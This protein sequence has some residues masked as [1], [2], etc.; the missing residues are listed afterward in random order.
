[1]IS[2]KS[3]ASLEKAA[4]KANAS[5]D[6]LVELSIQRLLPIISRE[7]QKHE[8]RKEILNQINHFWEKGVELLTEFETDLGDDDPTTIHFKSAIKALASAHNEI[9]AFVDKGDIIESFDLQHL[10]VSTQQ[11]DGQG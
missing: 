8:M 4:Q 10:A 7:R 3:L 11:P 9:S 6:A 5:R 1:M 2:R